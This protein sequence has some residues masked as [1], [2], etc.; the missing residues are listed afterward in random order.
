MIYKTMKTVKRHKIRITRGRDWYK[1]L[2]DQEL[3][4]CSFGIKPPSKSHFWV[5]HSE[6]VRLKLGS[7]SKI[8]PKVDCKYLGIV[9]LPLKGPYIPKGTP[10]G[11]PR[12]KSVSFTLQNLKD[13]FEAGRGSILGPD[14]VIEG[15]TYYSFESW[16]ESLK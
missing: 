2:V 10:S 12:T 6:N 11:R 13:A 3:F 16:L 5:L 1:D 8:V 7:Y 9:E 15:E 14:E 4:V